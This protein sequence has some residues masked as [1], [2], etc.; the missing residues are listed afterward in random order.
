MKFQPRLFLSE[1]LTR[2][3]LRFSRYRTFNNPEEDAAFHLE[4][5]RKEGVEALDSAD[6]H[7]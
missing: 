2:P 3:L 5:S 6:V 7:G 1:P 4:P